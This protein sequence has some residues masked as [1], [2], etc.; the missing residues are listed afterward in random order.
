LQVTHVP[1]RAADVGL[2]RWRRAD[3]VTWR[4][5]HVDV[6]FELASLF[7]NGGSAEKYPPPS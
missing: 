4:V 3:D 7:T 6:D 1:T 5:V 2:E